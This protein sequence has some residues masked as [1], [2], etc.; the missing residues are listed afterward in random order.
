M[1]YELPVIGAW[2]SIFGDV[3]YSL[4]FSLS[5]QVVLRARTP[6]SSSISLIIAMKRAVTTSIALAATALSPFRRVLGSHHRCLRYSLNGRMEHRTIFKMTFW[7]WYVQRVSVRA[8]SADAW[9]HKKHNENRN[10]IL[11]AQIIENF[12]GGA[13]NMTESVVEEAVDMP[14]NLVE[15]TASVGENAVEKTVDMTEQALEGTEKMVTTPFDD[16]LDQLTDCFG[17]LPA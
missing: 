2:S 13:V 10:I 4:V 12:V 1:T 16:F 14:T 5:Y 3:T 7:R 11:M 6:L 9:R 15:E 17:L 8:R